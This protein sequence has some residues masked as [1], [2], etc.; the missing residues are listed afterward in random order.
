MSKVTLITPVDSLQG[1]LHKRSDVIFR[2]KHIYD[3]KGNVIGQ[4][5]QESYRVLNPRDWKKNPPKGAEKTNIDNWTIACQRASHEL[6]DEVLAAAW[7]KRFEAQ[8]THPEP[9]API[10]PRT[11]RPKIYIRL[12]CFVRATIYRTLSK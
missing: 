10:D 9:D 6:K 7:K 2:R 1:K 3:S 5:A 8:L 4:L 11:R 12:A